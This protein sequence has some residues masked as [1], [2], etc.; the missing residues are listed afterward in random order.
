MIRVQ[1]VSLDE[2][3]KELERDADGGFVRDKIVRSCGM[4]RGGVPVYTRYLVAGYV[5]T[6]GDIVALEYEVGSSMNANSE[7]MTGKLK[8]AAEKMEQA[9][10][11]LGGGDYELRAG[12]FLI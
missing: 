5:N 1:F 8:A 12:R 2:F 3:L 10:G 9:V 4:V 11:R 7:E 6:N